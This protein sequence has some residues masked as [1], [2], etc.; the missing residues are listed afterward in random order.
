MLD[1]VLSSMITLG[2]GYETMIDGYDA[3]D[4]GETEFEDEN[5]G[6]AAD[7]FETAESRFET[8]TETFDEDDD[9][10]DELDTHVQTARCQSSGLAT[11]AGHFKA[12]ATAAD[13]ND[14]QTAQ[15]E[16]SAAEDAL[17]SVDTCSS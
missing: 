13:D 14:P 2:D 1:D 10:P 16:Q 9:P 8:A 7:A 17:D 12:S 5:F 15:N 3:L 6:A 4:Q 11:A